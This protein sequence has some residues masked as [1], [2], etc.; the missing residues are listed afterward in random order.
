MN[1]FR[2]RFPK[3][4]NVFIIFDI[5]VIKLLLYPL[6]LLSLMYVVFIIPLYFR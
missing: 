6:I 2:L 5:V 3:F 1:F 4:F